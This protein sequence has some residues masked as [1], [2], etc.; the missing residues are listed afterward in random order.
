MK[1]RY[2]VGQM[3]EMRIGARQGSGPAGT[4]EVLFCLPHDD[5]PLLYR[6]KP[7]SD[8]RERVVAEGDLWP[9]SD[10]KVETTEPAAMF[11]IAIGRR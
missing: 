9:S 6:V 3:L 5:G 7:L 8:N 4:C 11:S 10:A 2:R 1:H